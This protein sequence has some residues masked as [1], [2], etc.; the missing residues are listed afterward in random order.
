MK[1]Y[2]I[3]RFA[4]ELQAAAAHASIFIPQRQSQPASSVQA[5]DMLPPRMHIP[6]F[7]RSLLPLLLQLSVWSVR[8]VSLHAPRTLRRPL[9]L[10]A[11]T[12]NSHGSIRY[13]A[14]AAS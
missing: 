3:S 5:H 9:L 13:I 14:N 7:H 8:H 12:C 4:T 10:S 6:S 11:Q 1:E 2:F